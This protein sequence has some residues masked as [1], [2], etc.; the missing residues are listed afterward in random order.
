M[1][2]NLSTVFWLS[3]WVKKYFWS[4]L[5]LIVM[6]SV[7][8]LLR[9][10]LA[11]LSK[12]L[13]DGAVEGVWQQAMKACLSFVLI[14]V[15][16]IV[17]KGI[18]TMLSVNTLETMSNQMR[19]KLFHRLSHMR[20]LD[21]SMYHTG[22]LMTRITS[23]VNIV[24]GG[25]VRAV[26]E[27]IALTT[28]VL[29]AVIT[30]FVYDPVMA[31]YAMFLGPAAMLGAY[32][33]GSRFIGIHEKAQEAESSFRSYIQESLEHILILKT[34]C[35]E[36]AMEQNLSRLQEAKKRLVLK[37]SLAS[38]ITS[39]VVTGGFWFC[40]LMVFGWGAY[41][42]YKGSISFG[43]LTVFIQLV[44]QV[45][46]PFMELAGILPQAMGTFSSARRLLKLEGAESEKQYGEE[47]KKDFTCIH[48]E[49]IHFSYKDETPVL[50]ELS[51]QIR[52]GEIIGLTGASG[53]GKTTLI[54]ILMQLIEPQKGKIFIQ[55]SQEIL[56]TEASLRTLI[57]YVPQGNTLFSG[58]IAENLRIGRPDATK[59]EMLTALE[60]ADAM[61]F[62]SKLENG[63]DTVIGE[64]GIGL[65]EGQ[66]QRIAIAR[67]L[68]KRAPILVLDEATSAL[69]TDTEERVLHAIITQEKGRTCIIITHRLTLL[70]FCNRVL[71]LKKG[72]LYEVSGIS[73]TYVNEALGG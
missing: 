35:R 65:S 13:I 71:Q 7:L 41:K 18:S 52:K 33:F 34:F 16:Q 70:Q 51:F 5:I 61:Y 26:P 17:L 50:Q 46:S 29:A 57:A 14:I 64:R 20:W 19:N 3:V 73:S 69:D 53:E 66:A 12:E 37:K 10:V 28:G 44:A 8:S 67:A 58:S 27:I 55:N 47:G 11:V 2:R 39:T 25:L 1:K 23:D 56:Q 72:R 22:D 40:Y 4:L 63:I 9:V 6:G 59:D 54:H 42:L 38:Q 45:Q 30:L 21:Y 24:T 48:L 60:A 32:I 43:T 36:E 31:V 15:L 49:G 62:I 68:I